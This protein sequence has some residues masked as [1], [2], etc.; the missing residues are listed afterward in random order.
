MPAEV[1]FV[2]TN[3]AD[4]V[5]ACQYRTTAPSDY[6]EFTPIDLTGSEL[7]MMARSRPEV[8]EV[9]FHLTSLPGGG[10][11]VTS[12]TEG[13]FTVI[14]PRARLRAMP[15]GTYYHSLIRIRP[16]G[17]YERIWSG[18]IIHSVG[19]TRDE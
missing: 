12:A 16:D 5:R 18:T 1:T 10:I 7:H 19:P 8:H 14:I 15:A 13:K 9:S 6:E 17:F 3:E 2:T 4:T 11:M